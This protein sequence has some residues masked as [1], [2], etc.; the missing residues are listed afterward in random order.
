[1]SNLADDKQSNALFHQV[2]ERII[3]PRQKPQPTHEGQFLVCLSVLVPHS[4][5]F[6]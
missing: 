4:K 1:L 5:V 2:I 3:L 6:D